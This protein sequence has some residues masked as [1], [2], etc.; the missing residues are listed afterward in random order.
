MTLE[1]CEIGPES[2]MWPFRFWIT[3]IVWTCFIF[4]LLKHWISCVP[5]KAKP[6]MSGQRIPSSPTGMETIIIRMPALP[7]GRRTF[8]NQR[9]DAALVKVTRTQVTTSVCSWAHAG[10]RTPQWGLVFLA[11]PGET[12][13]TASTNQVSSSWT[14]NVSFGRTK[15][16]RGGWVA[17]VGR[18][19]GED[20]AECT[21]LPGTSLHTNTV[22]TGSRLRV[23]E[24][25]CS[26]LK[27]S[28]NKQKQGAWSG[29]GTEKQE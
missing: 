27:N 2:L 19:E 14:K 16:G 5:F 23:Q 8:F 24:S 9:C 25:R 7:E 26:H 21:Y 4:I 12:D 15:E 1:I 3:C 6:Q 10:T 29:L 17:A 13:C 28:T 18:W 22:H 20:S 11:V